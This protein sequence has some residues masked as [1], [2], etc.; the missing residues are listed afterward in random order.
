MV[1]VVKVKAELQVE[2]KKVDKIHT[3]IF[4]LQVNNFIFTYIIIRHTYYFVLSNS[5]EFRS[6]LN[7]NKIPMK[8]E[9]VERN[10]HCLIFFYKVSVLYHLLLL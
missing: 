3:V 1:K 7:K 6:T 10:N 8:N 5:L 9:R 2:K 4:V